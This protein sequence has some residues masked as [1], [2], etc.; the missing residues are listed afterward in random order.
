M[1]VCQQQQYIWNGVIIIVV[2]V[3]VVVVVDGWITM[4]LRRR[5]LWLCH[6]A[7]LCFHRQIVINRSVLRQ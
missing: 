6:L 1:I 5:M 3:V 7:S 2:V 4:S